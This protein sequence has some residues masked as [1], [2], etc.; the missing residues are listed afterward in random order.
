M[1]NCHDQFRILVF[2][3]SSSSAS[4][5]LFAGRAGGA[6]LMLASVAAAVDVA[7]EA[8]DVTGISQLCFSF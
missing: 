4:I 1:I 2:V 3:F 5:G 6:E 7:S 8:I